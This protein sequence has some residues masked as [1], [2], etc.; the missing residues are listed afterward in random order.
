MGRECI[1][2]LSGK[3]SVKTENR[4][5][6]VKKAAVKTRDVIYGRP[7]K[8]FSRQALTRSEIEKSF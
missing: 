5:E 8:R 7:Q 6:G 1:V 2:F 3:K 4:E